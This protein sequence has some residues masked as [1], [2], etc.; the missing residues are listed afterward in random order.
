MGEGRVSFTSALAHRSKEAG[1][2]S[3][4]SSHKPSRSKTHPHPIPSPVAGAGTS[5]VAVIHFNLPRGLAD[6]NQ[7]QET[8]SLFPG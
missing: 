2:R 7:P 6:H 1:P 3:P 4:V 5:N 8:V